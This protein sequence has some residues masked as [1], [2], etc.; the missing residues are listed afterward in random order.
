VVDG[1][2]GRQVG[3][4][5]DMSVDLG[6][7]S[8]FDV[9]DA[10]QGFSVWTEEVCGRGA[11]WYIL[12]PNLYGKRP[13]GRLFAGIA[14]KLAHGVAISWDGLVI[15]HCTSLSQPDGPDGGRVGDGRNTLRTIFMERL[16]VWDSGEDS[17]VGTEGEL[18]DSLEVAVEPFV[19]KRRTRRGK[20]KKKRRKGCVQHEDSPVGRVVVASPT[21]NPTALGIGYQEPKLG[22]S[23]VEPEVENGSS[24]V[25]ATP[26]VVVTTGVPVLGEQVVLSDYRIPIRKRP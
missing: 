5:V 14:V 11:N 25:V 20:R 26:P 4:T 18:M 22:L 7:A 15:R 8:H 3:Y 13:D 12:M 16:H 19:S 1:A 24:D 17:K 9:H 21:L 6:N 2:D 10:S 23:P